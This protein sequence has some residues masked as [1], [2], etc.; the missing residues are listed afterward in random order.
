MTTRRSFL[1]GAIPAA[2]VP[3]LTTTLHAQQTESPATSLPPAITALRNRRAEA[4][5]ITSAERESR[6]ARARGIA[7]AEIEKLIAG[8]ARGRLAGL[9]GENRVNVL[10]LNLALDLR[11]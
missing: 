4:V 7:P 2:L 8:H 10:E 5:P 11:R 1:A 6:I 9:I 3:A